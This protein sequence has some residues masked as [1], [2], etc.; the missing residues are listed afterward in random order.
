[1]ADLSTDVRYVKGVGE[2]RA[3]A[4]ARLGSPTLRAL[5]SYF[6]RA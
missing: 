6:P 4:L 3:K 2:Q 5:I 1:M